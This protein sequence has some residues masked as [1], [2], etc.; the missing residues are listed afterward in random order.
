MTAYTLITGPT[1]GIGLALAQELAARGDALLLVGR[2]ADALAQTAASLRA[3]YPVEVLERVCDLA[4]PAQVTQ[5][6]E[7]IARD[8]LKIGL[9]VNNAGFTTSGAFIGQ[10]WR[11]ELA[12]LQVNVVTLAQL[13]HAIGRRMAEAGSGQILNVSSVSAFMPGPW[14]S[15][16]AA[17]KAY[18]LHFSEGLRE[19]L[20]PRG[21]RVSVLCPGTTRSPF[22]DKAG[23]AI[24]K[25]A[26]PPMIMTPADVAR[27][28]VRALERNQAIIIPRWRNRILAV[29]PRLAP[30]WVL[31]KVI[32]SLYKSVLK[33]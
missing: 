6:V 20:A 1:S 13:C 22:F 32:S 24:D 3:Q 29:S 8:G 9:L 5:L 16:Y 7:G 26:P 14:M 23:I 10:D 2:R 30:R 12:L 28:T 21:V 11:E 31:R 19:E 4:D 18:V 17:A 15:N 33:V 25:A 27:R